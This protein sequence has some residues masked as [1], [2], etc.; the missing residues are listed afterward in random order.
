MTNKY[1]EELVLRIKEAGQELI[2]R[3]EQMI[4]KDADA[5]SDFSLYI[6]LN[7]VDLLVPTIEWSTSVISKNTLDRMREEKK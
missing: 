5:I 6:N 3:A 1:R 7:Q 2:D 4:S